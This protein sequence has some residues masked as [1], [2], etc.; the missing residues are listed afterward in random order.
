MVL[1]V[2]EVVLVVIVVVIAVGGAG[3]GG[4]CC[5]LFTTSPRTFKL[6]SSSELTPT[7]AKADLESTTTSTGA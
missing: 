3:G 7:T 1:V 5:E 4:R 2:L 6:W